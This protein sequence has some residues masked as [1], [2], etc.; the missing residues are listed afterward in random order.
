MNQSKTQSNMF[1]YILKQIIFSFQSFFQQLSLALSLFQKNELLNHA[2]AGAFFFLLSIT[3]MLLLLLFS[4]D[5]YIISYQQLLQNII[6]FLKTMNAD[7]DMQFLINI[8]LF[9]LNTSAIGLFGLLNLVWASRSILT[10]IQRGLGVIFPSDTK[11]TTIWI[12]IRSF[13]ILSILLFVSL[14]IIII[15]IGFNLWKTLLIQESTQGAWYHGIIPFTK[16]LFPFIIVVSIIFSIYRFVP[17]QKPKT[18]PSLIGAMF[19]AVAVIFLHVTFSKFFTVT[20]YNVIYGLLGSFILMVLWIHFAFILFFFFAE[21]TYVS[22]KLDILSFERMYFFHHHD[23]KQ[24]GINIDRLLFRN[25]KR[26]FEKFAKFYPKDHILFKQGDGCTDIFYVYAGRIGIF[27]EI[28]GQEKKIGCVDQGEF[29]GEM[30]YLLSEKRMAT[31]IVDED[32]ILI[33]IKPHVFDQLLK[34]NHEISYKVIKM[35]CNRLKYRHVS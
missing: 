3:P 22:D 7:W 15:S 30:A 32:S 24:K 35:L 34:V 33:N 27:C 28:H 29:L 16:Y 9:D 10:S 8:G 19:F 2:G 12:N 13:F 31:A 1:L 4:M 5:R 14:M 21:F 18:I 26:M 20:R 25:P 23:T 11:K 6:T 17:A